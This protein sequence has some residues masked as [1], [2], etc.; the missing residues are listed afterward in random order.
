MSANDV[1]TIT[2]KKNGFIIE[3]KDISSEGYYERLKA[4]S[5]KEM[6]TEAKRLQDYNI[7]EYGIIFIDEQD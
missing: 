7:D 2:K 6:W 4:K 1:I 5:Y 3:H